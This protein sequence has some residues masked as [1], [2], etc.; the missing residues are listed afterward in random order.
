MEIQESRWYETDI[1]RRVQYSF[2]AIST[3]LCDEAQEKQMKMPYEI[4][5][6]D[7]HG[8][9]AT[10]ILNPDSGDWLWMPHVKHGQPIEGEITA[11]LTSGNGRLY[12]KFRWKRN[13]SQQ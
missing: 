9:V 4:D 12:R 7:E 13:S 10:F 1:M 3:E 6:K 11:V 2:D 5:F 8:S